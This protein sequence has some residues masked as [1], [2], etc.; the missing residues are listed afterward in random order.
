MRATLSGLRAFGEAFSAIFEHAHRVG[1]APSDRRVRVI[2][3]LP[4][5]PDPRQAVDVYLPA[6]HLHEGERRP[7]LVFAHG[8]GWIACNRRMVSPLA[9]TLAA[10]GF[11]V[12]TPGYR[13]LPHCDRAAQRKD[14]H[15]ALAWVI[16]H[17]ATRFGLDLSRL[18]V[19]GESAGAHLIMRAVQDWDPAWLKPRGVIGVYGLYDVGHLADDVPPMLEPVRLAIKQG[20]AFA[21][22]A[23]DH[24]ALR[25]LPWSDVP[26]LLLHG[27]DDVIVPVDQSHVMHA[28]LVEHGHNVEL[29]TF[30]G[31]SH[32]FI[33][34]SDPVRRKTAVRAYRTLLR[35]LL[36]VTTRSTPRRSHAR[37]PSRLPASS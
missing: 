7:T 5:G 25:R 9:R 22:A 17:G 18:V 3:D 1:L 6:G 19:G 12:I 4:Y 2:R 35:F 33:Y 36:E 27:E 24:S 28:M 26:I 34:Q 23:R 10:R 37:H 16:D 15:D 30:P 32:G 21:D 14:L 8:G 31:A 29:R 13:L 11:A 20:D